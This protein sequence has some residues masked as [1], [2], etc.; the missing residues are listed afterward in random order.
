MLIV[1]FIT[2]IMSVL[3][4]IIKVKAFPSRIQSYIALS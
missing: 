2:F 4:V 1:L 3:I